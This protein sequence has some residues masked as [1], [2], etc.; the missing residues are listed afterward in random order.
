MSS[1][2]YNTAAWK[3]LRAAKLAQDPLCEYCRQAGRITAAREVDHRQ[4]IKNGGD[5]WDWTNLTST[6][7]AC[8]SEKTQADRRGVPW[9]RK[10]CSVDGRP[11]DP[12][13][14]WNQEKPK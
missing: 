10:G 14:W 13:H 2:P 5:P 6:C 7:S 4:S 12:T 8:H 3:R 11:L 1:W 9:R